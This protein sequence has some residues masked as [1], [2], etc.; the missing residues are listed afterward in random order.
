[1]TGST[2]WINEEYKLF[3]FGERGEIHWEGSQLS[4]KWKNGY[5]GKIFNSHFIKLMKLKR[6]HFNQC[7]CRILWQPIHHQSSQTTLPDVSDLHQHLYSQS[8]NCL[9]NNLTLNPALQHMMASVTLV[10][11]QHCCLTMI[12][13]WH[14]S[15]HCLAELYIHLKTNK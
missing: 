5:S 2:C 15:W 13:A 12:N 7:A 9:L 6:M 1:M 11:H 14:V 10:W 8:L 3:C 4:S